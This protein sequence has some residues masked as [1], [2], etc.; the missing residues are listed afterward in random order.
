[1]TFGTCIAGKKGRKFESW[2][3]ASAKIQRDTTVQ[4]HPERKKATSRSKGGNNTIVT[5]QNRCGKGQRKG[6]LEEEVSPGHQ[7]KEKDS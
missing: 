3:R 1:M 7:K 4:I 6:R 2:S 5:K